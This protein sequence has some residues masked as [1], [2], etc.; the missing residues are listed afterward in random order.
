MYEKHLNHERFKCFFV[1][2]CDQFSDYT[3]GYFYIV[4][5]GDVAYT[6][7]RSVLLVGRYHYG[8]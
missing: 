8:T 3:Y 5:K 2:F 6:V 4:K 1:R 7:S